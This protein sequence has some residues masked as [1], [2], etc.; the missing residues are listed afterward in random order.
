MRL[1]NDCVPANT[2]SPVMV[3][4]VIG[5]K[6]LLAVSTFEK[7][8]PSFDNCHEPRAPLYRKAGPVVASETRKS[9]LPVT[10]DPSPNVNTSEFV[11]VSVFWLCNRESFPKTNCF[12]PLPVG[13]CLIFTFPLAPRMSRSP[14]AV[15][16]TR[17]WIRSA[18]TA[19]GTDPKRFRGTI[20]ESVPIR[21]P[22]K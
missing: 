10:A 8:V 13:N 7:V 5:K 2:I 17:P 3:P 22:I 12:D 11:P 20:S 16:G 15:P 14:F 18:F 1:A 4:P 9:K 19:D 6:L 21:M